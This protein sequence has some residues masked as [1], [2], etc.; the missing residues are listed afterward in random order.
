MAEQFKKTY[1][2][3]TEFIDS[4]E[5]EIYELTHLD[6]FSYL[7]INE[8]ASGIE[9]DFFPNYNREEQIFLNVCKDMV[10]LQ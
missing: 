4:W 6:Y 1:V 8:M 10:Y 9:N 7:L 3:V 2:S 5:K